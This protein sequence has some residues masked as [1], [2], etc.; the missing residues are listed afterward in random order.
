MRVIEIETKDLEAIS[1]AL[2]DVIMSE[3]ETIVYTAVF[4]DDIEMDVKVCGCQDEPAY[5]E[6]V[7][8]KNG[9]E[10]GCTDCMDEILGEWTLEYNGKEYT[11]IV[12]EA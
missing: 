4:D 1:K 11:T 2:N 10:V 5:T 8:F 12:C 9:Y 7:L 6:A 3:D